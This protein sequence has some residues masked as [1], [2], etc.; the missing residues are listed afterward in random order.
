MRG[1]TLDRPPV[2]LPLL[3]R[4]GVAP[5]AFFGNNN[6]A[7]DTTDDDDGGI[8][9]QG[10]HELYMSI[11]WRQERVVAEQMKGKALP[12]RQGSFDG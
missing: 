11:N 3:V 4:R 10:K 7:R 2:A 5:S 8:Q 1:P 9:N 12:S 6:D